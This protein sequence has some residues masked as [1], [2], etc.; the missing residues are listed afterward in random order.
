MAMTA[1]GSRDGGDVDCCH[2]S[3][4]LK[5]SCSFTPLKVVRKYVQA[6]TQ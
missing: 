6:Q 5:L 2:M 1:Y 3:I 4:P